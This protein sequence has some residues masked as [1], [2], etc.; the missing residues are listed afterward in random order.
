MPKAGPDEKQGQG[1]LLAVVVTQ[2]AVAPVQR[3]LGDGIQQAK[4]R[5]NSP[6]RQNFDFQI[7]TG[8]VVDL[9]GEIK[10]EF[11]EDVDG[12]PSALEAEVDGTCARAMAGKPIVAA[13][14]V[15]AAAPLRNLRRDA[16]VCA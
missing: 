10:S 4:G 6:C 14:A 5:Y 13:A 9:L 1:V 7:S 11:V 15:P 12:G 16:P 2:H 8:H 3:S